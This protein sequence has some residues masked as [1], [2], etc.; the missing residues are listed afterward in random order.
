MK[1]RVFDPYKEVSYKK[2]KE[3]FEERKAAKEGL[4]RIQDNLHK[5][6]LK[7]A[8]NALKGHQG[9]NKSLGNVKVTLPKLKFLDN[10]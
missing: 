4:K 5:D 10:E 1:F 7:K 6:P 9:R 8:F 3:R 2:A